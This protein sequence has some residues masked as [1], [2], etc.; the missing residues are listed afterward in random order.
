MDESAELLIKTRHSQV[1]E[2]LESFIKGLPRGVH[3][4]APEV[5]KMAKEQ[6]LKVSLSTVYRTLNNLSVQGQ[7]QALSG[8]HG[9]RYEASDGGHDHDHLICVKCGLTIEFEDD[10]IRG[11]GKTVA[12]RK[13]YEYKHSRFDILGVCQPC[14][15][16]GDD[17]RIDQSIRTVEKMLAA[18]ESITQELELSLEQLQ[19]RKLVRAREL[20]DNA[21]LQIQEAGDEFERSLEFLDINAARETPKEG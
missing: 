4:T 5:F 15:S 8:E 1:Q 3:L 11:F 2:S 18:C 21:Y 16:Q 13:G 19:L 14:R 12:D 9:R 6:G 17:H 10:L 7:V 20:M